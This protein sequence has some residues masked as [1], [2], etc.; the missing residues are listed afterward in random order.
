[1][2]SQPS[3]RPADVPF[4]TLRALGGVV[5][6]AM[7]PDANVFTAS[8]TEGNKNYRNCCKL[9][10]TA[11]AHGVTLIFSALDGNQILDFYWIDPV[12]AAKRFISRPKFSRKQYTQFKREWSEQRAGKR[13]FSRANSGLIFQSCQAVDKYSSPLILLFY[14]DK[15]FS[16]KH[17]THHPIYSK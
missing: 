7:T 15:S 3:Y 6:T 4:Q 8:M 17:R 2:I 16:G 9:M 11:C 14:A 1:V 5:K 12:D 13:A 10:I